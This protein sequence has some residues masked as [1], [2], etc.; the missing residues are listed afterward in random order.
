MVTRE[1][2][3]RN[4]R[5]LSGADGAPAGSVA[6]LIEYF[7][8]DAMIEFVDQPGLPNIITVP[9]RILEPYDS[10]AQAA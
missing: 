10:G 4:V 1:H 8:D 9:C 2:L 6:A 7:G 3:Y 5:L